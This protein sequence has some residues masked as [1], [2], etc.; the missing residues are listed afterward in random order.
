MQLAAEHHVGGAVGGIL[1]VE[2]AR[3]KLDGPSIGAGLLHLEALHQHG[4]AAAAVVHVAQGIVGRDDIAAALDAGVVAVVRLVGDD[5]HAQHVLA[6]N[7]GIALWRDGS[8]AQVQR[9]AV[10]AEVDARGVGGLKLEVI[11]SHLL[12]EVD[13]VDIVVFKFLDFARLHVQIHGA[14]L[15]HGHGCDEQSDDRKYSLFHCLFLVLVWL[16]KSYFLNL[17]LLSPTLMT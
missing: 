13:V 2:R 11:G 3:V 14:V 9:V 12:A 8:V 7:G 15:C 5:I 1:D 6:G 16:E 17:A 10:A 4:V